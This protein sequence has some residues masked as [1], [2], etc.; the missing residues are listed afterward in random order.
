M[1]EGGRGDEG[2]EMVSNGLIVQVTGGIVCVAAI[3]ILLMA[4]Y[5]GTE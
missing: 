2:K 1:F 4:Q 3:R 5:V